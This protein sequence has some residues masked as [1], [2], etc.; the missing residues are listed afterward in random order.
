MKTN[1]KP[2]RVAPEELPA[3]P[4]VRAAQIVRLSPS[5]LRLWAAGSGKRT[6]LFKPARPA[7]LTLAFSNLVEVFVLASMRRVHG[8]SMQRVRKALAYVGKELGVDRPLIHT[9]F[10]TDGARLFVERADKLLDVS[11]AGQV[12]LRQL[13]DASLERIE[14]GHEVAVRLYPWVRADMGSGQPKSIVIDPSRG[15]G[16]PIVSGTGIQAR[17]IAE[18]YRAGESVAG[19]ANDYLLEV[20]QVEDAIRCE[21]SEAA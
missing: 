16:Q 3:Y 11:S 18:R 1:A 14:W 20:E 2:D 7:P 19:L 8:I 6:P 15:F 5:T 21:T 10:R 9:C 4:A 17:I 13:L 12:A